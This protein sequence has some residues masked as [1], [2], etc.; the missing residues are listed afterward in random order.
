LTE[1]IGG[2]SS[3]PEKPCLVETRQGFSVLYK[4]RYLYSKY[5]PSRAIV[6]AVKSM[7]VLPGTLILAASPCLWYGLDEILS[8][9]D[10][11][12]LLVG[13]EADPA[14]YE[15]TKQKLEE[16]SSLN[17]EIQ[18]KVILLHRGD[19]KQIHLLFSTSGNKNSLPP[20]HQFKRAILMEMSGGSQFNS[21]LYKNAAYNTESV[22]ANFWKNRIT[23][24][25][26]GRL[27]ARNIFH[28]LKRLENARNFAALSKTIDKPIFVIGAGESAEKTIEDL[29]SH[30]FDKTNGE[31][32]QNLPCYILCVDAALPLLMKNHI[33][34]DG[35]VAV[36]S[37]LAI[38]KAYIGCGE[39]DGTIFADLTSRS[40][41]TNHTRGNI[42]YFT[43]TYCDAAFLTE[44]DKKGLL[45]SPIPP[46]GSVGL[47][48]VHIALNLRKS[49]DIP[50]FVSGLDFSYSLGKT[51][52]RG[53][54]AHTLRL[55]RQKRILPLENYDA[56]FKEGAGCINGKNGPVYTDKSLSSYASQ[57]QNLFSAEAFLFDVGQSGIPLNLPR[58]EKT[59]WTE[60]LQKWEQKV[61]NSKTINGIFLEGEK[62]KDSSLGKKVADYI[63]DEKKA[64]ERIK[65][66][67]IEGKKVEKEIPLEKELENLLKGREYLYLHFPDG[68]KLDCSN[69]SFL[70]R[71]RSELDFFLKDLDR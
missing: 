30:V 17:S 10:E 58:M 48:A 44:L 63:N 6:E 14:L 66:I 29:K 39:F 18:S 26:L 70:K 21:D 67:L 13:L 2:C 37:Q 9:L 47:V 51:H 28:N 62:A 5:N 69:L 46:M 3:S 1:S 53:A 36:E 42:C 64:L 45:P 25:K 38:E 15:L 22:I 54:P 4:E 35:V 60:I 59:E 11:K 20:L 8:K 56:A 34:V 52:A 24:V 68:Y 50:V 61:S 19:I 33:P 57:F 31:K 43:S 65:E 27:F 32:I 40:Q 12:S 7:T 23:L 55:S 41:V 71:V 16:L 49:P